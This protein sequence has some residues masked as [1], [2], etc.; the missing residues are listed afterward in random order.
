LN[1]QLAVFGC[2]WL[3]LPLAV[4]LANKGYVVR[5]ST[6]SEHKL[7]LLQSKNIQAFLIQLSEQEITGAI[8]DFMTG[9]AILVI[10]VPPRL[11]GKETEN[12]VKKMQLLQLAVKRHDVKKVI[13]VSSTSVYG[14]AEGE[15]TEATPPT[16]NTNA[17]KQLLEAENVFVNTNSFQTTVL[18]L[19][20]LIGDDRHPIKML[21]GRKGL[22]NGNQYI[23]LI[24]RPDCIHIIEHIIANNWYD[25]IINGVYPFHPSKLKYYTAI[26]HKRGLQ[27]PEY[28]LH[29]AYLGKKVVPDALLNVK[30]FSFHTSI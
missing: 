21:S 4:S 1:K 8:D 19:G 7:P 2:G 26:A 15:V 9:V 16:P 20:G 29:N 28:E 30:N 14:N 5:G 23:N 10:N 11:R 17:G 6:T 24:Q 27:P 18:R 25:T 12:Y 13:F 3:G 22:T